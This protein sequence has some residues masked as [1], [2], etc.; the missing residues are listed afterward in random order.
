MEIRTRNWIEMSLDPYAL[1]K[2]RDQYA[3]PI[4]NTI[5]ENE[6]AAISMSKREP[7]RY[8][9]EDEDAVS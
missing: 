9:E 8:D 2:K 6:D 7:S 3:I 5:E 4:V 1:P